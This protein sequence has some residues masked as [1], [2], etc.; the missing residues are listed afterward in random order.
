MAKQYAPLQSISLLNANCKSQP[1][2]ILW[3]K[4]NKDKPVKAL[5]G[6]MRKYPRIEIDQKAYDGLQIEAVLRHKST[7]EIATEALL[8]HI[9]KEALSVLD[10]KTIGPENEIPETIA[11]KRPLDHKTTEDE[12]GAAPVADK[13]KRLADNPDAL[14]A[15]RDMWK[16]GE[17]NQA[18][19]AR[20][21]GYHRATVNDAIQR[22]KKSGE[23]VD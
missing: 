16:A 1:A 7:R 3:S 20:R 22:M 12:C 15:I 2:I 23:L 19:I 13:R 8:S 5:Y 18:E 4:T 17:H 21:I 11:T 9:S 6:P 10:H 14:Q